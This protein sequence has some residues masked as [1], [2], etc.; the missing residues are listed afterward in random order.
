MMR[1]WLMIG[2]LLPLIAWQSTDGQALRDAARTGDI[3]TAQRLLDAGVDVDAPDRY[4]STALSFAAR[5]GHLEVVRLLLERGA[6]PDVFDTFYGMS[7]VSRALQE[8]HLEI[9]RLLL[10]A[11]ATDGTSAIAAA[12][13]GDDLALAQLGVAAAPMPSATRDQLLQMAERAGREDIAVVL[14]AAPVDDSSATGPPP[15]PLAAYVGA[16]RND[17]SGTLVRV[18]EADG[19]LLAIVGA[20]PERRLESTGGRTFHGV[21]DAGLTLGF[22][23]RGTSVEFLQLQD[24]ET[25]SGLRPLEAEEAALLLGAR[26]EVS[27][28]TVPGDLRAATPN[29][30]AFRGPGGSG[31]SDGH[32]VPVAWDVTSGHNIAWKTALPG[33]ANSSPVV[34]GDRIFVS[35]AVGSSGDDAV[36]TGLYGDVE[37]VEDLSPH[38]FKVFAVDRRSGE[39]VWDRTVFAG[40]PQ[41]KRHPKSSQ[42]NSTPVTDGEH[43]VVLFGS[44]G[45]L[46]CFDFEGREL[47]NQDIGVL[48][49]GWF[50]DPDFQWGHAASPLIYDD[51]VI[52]QADVQRDPFIAAYD[53]SSGRE[54]WRTSRDEI[55]TFSTPAIYRGK[56]GDEVITN[57]TTI[58]AYDP[59]SGEELWR[60]G[61]NSEVVVATPIVTDDMIYVT[62]GYPPV[63]PIYA[64]R[65]G[66]SGDISLP[67]GVESN[68][69]VLWSKERG[70]TYIPS[71]LLYRG[72]LY[73]ANN[74]GRLTAYDAVTGTMVLRARIGGTGG[75]FVASPVAGDGYLFIGSEEGTVFVLR[76]GTQYEE[77]AANEMNEVVWA[78]PAL[79]PGLLVV[80]T[81][82]HLYGIGAAR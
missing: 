2:L 45:R 7:A 21:D 42:A 25:R 59:R 38:E 26:P 62:A 8:G 75:S 66:G 34:W 69:S 24:G 9:A 74:D 37:P 36:R 54:V 32:D 22:F 60:L 1:R 44:V 23:G 18:R 16:Y 29:W 40:A 5:A 33:L 13:E 63:R 27:A 47:W 73:T 67:A 68:E 41:V 80:R 64:V 43:V 19:Q 20:A 78:T 50:Y 4:A 10:E 6:D 65:P 11:G 52:V 49:S 17:D 46:A 58:R 72:L 76:A 51:L 3:A 15:L 28:T 61:P 55:P 56:P 82:G 57:G 48:D 77:I 81:L 53:L 12:I 71:P 79:T 30:P 70:G 35:T 39:V 14:R 31:V